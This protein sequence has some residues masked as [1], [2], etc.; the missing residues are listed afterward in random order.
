MTA[1]AA[2]IQSLYDSYGCYLGSAY[3]QKIVAWMTEH[4]HPGYAAEINALRATYNETIGDAGRYWQHCP[5]TAET[6]RKINEAI[7]DEFSAATDRYEDWA[8]D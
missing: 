1:S 5:F 8:S 4:N 3:E 2:S 7:A 6:L